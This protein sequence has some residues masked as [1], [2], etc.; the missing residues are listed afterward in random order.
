MTNRYILFKL[1]LKAIRRFRV[2]IKSRVPWVSTNKH[3]IR[4][5]VWSIGIYSGTSPFE[6]TP[7][8]GIDNPVIYPECI[9]GIST[10]LVADPFMVKENNRWLMF[11]EVLNRQ[12]KKGEIGLAESENGLS[13]RFRQIVLNE[14]HHLSYPYV[15]RWQD[16]HYMLPECSQT[17]SVRLYKA[18]SFPIEWSYEATL[19]SGREYVDPSIFRFDNKWWLF[20]GHGAPPN[21]ADTLRLFYADQLHGPWF[22]HPKSPIV[23][24]NPRI[25][26]PA[27]RV[28]VFD[29]K[30]VRF[31]QDC[32]LEYGSNV[33]AFEISDLTT[34]TYA[35]IKVKENP[36]L[37]GSGSGWNSQGAHH[38]DLHALVDGGWL[39]CVDGWTFKKHVR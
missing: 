21:L 11:F 27:G 23:D 28:L 12:A 20:A 24:G 2:A 17:N 30:I 3:R 13:W 36:V 19:L 33:H 9:Q 32:S 16:N 34:T 6:I 4:P 1:L 29:N 31:S 18:S 8:D 22:E 25:A 38:V 26:R 35:E 39:A 15:F 37:A 5:R 7:V 10:N 14:A